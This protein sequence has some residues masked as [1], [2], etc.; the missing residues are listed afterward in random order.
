M[1]ADVVSRATSKDSS[2]PSKLHPRIVEE[3]SRD[4]RVHYGQGEKNSRPRR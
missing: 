4:E 2:T 3:T 1:H